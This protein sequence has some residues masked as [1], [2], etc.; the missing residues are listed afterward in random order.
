[1]LVAVSSVGCKDTTK[2]KVSILK[3]FIDVGITGTKAQIQNGG[4]LLLN[5][6]LNVHVD[7]VNKS[8]ADIFTMD[9][10]LETNDGPGVKETWT[11]KW[12]KGDVMSYD[13]KTTPSIKEGGHFVC[14]YVLNPN[15]LEDEV[16]ID[17]KLC[18]AL[19][20]TEFKVLSPYPNPTEDLVVIPLIVPSQGELLV[21]I[22]NVAGKPVKM[23][24]SE[25]TAQ[26]LQ[27]LTID[28]QGFSAGL[29]VCKVEL[30]GKNSIVKFIKK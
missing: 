20:E 2:G 14:V 17:N 22:Y 3:R 26:G 23:P 1:M 5:D 8:T 29:Y 6:Y 21:T 30:D 18:N 9:L 13:F 12:L 25:T 24:Y 27:F 16:P 28:A 15:G 7:L 4:G 10:Y 11:G 19:D